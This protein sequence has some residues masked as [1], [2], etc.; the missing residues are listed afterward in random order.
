LSRTPF[1]I[2]CYNGHI[3]IVKL[4]LNDERIDIDQVDNELSRTPFSVACQEGYIEIVKL[5][6][7]DQRVDI[8]QA[9]N[10]GWTF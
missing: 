5:L 2:A 8:N 9:D 7:N 4:L 6:L 3:E 1:Y 10:D